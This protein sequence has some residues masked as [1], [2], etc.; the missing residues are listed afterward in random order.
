MEILKYGT[1]RFA[2]ES[3]DFDPSFHEVVI[4]FDGPSVGIQFSKYVGRIFFP[5]QKACDQDFCNTII[6]LDSNHTQFYGRNIQSEFFAIPNG[7]MRI[8]L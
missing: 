5:V 2:G 6:Q 4:D 7:I 1:N 8:V 3:F